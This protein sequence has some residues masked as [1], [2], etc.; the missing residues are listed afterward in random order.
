VSH[1]K[2]NPNPHPKRCARSRFGGASGPVGAIVI[3][4]ALWWPCSPCWSPSATA[5]ASSFAAIG[6]ASWLAV[7]LAVT[8]VG[9]I[10]TTAWQ[11][12]PPTYRGRAPS[13]A[14]RKCAGCQHRSVRTAR[15]HR[16]PA[17]VHAGANCWCAARSRRSTRTCPVG[18]RR[19]SAKRCNSAGESRRN[20]TP[21]VHFTPRIPAPAPNRASRH[22]RRFPQICS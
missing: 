19:N 20:L 9:V 1:L 22:F 21:F 15:R 5:R 11:P 6:P 4:I 18:S 17:G 2:R 13:I 16:Q 7:L 10:L 12:T 14:S 8:L 3:C